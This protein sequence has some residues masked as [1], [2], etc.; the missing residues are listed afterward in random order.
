MVM[1]NNEFMLAK[2]AVR[3]GARREL[4]SRATRGSFPQNI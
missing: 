4:V 1:E 3:E 2:A